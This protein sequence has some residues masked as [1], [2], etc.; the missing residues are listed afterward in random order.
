PDKYTYGSSG[1]GSSHHLSMEALK[2]ALQL[3]LDHVPFRGSGQS[4]PALVGNQV[5][6]VFSALPSL[7]GFVSRGEVKLLA[8]NSATRYDQ[9][10]DVPAVAEVIPGYDFAPTVGVLARKGTPPEI[11]N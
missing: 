9:A 11:A 10:P 3:R 1:I 6:L 7:A 4:V 2:N 5:P 8:V